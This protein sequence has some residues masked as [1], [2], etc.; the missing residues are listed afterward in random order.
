[1]GNF[2]RIA[3]TVDLD[4]LTHNFHIL[5]D[6]LPRGCGALAVVKADAYGHGAV[7]V[8]KVLEK[9][10][11]A[12]FAVATP[13]EGFA[14]R[15]NGIQTPIL[16]LGYS[17][18]RH[19]ARLAKEKITQSVFSSS[20]ADALASNLAD[21]PLTIHIKIDTGMT[22]LGFSPDETMSIADVCHRPCFRAEGIFTHF[23][24]ADEENTEYFQKQQTAFGDC[25]KG[26]KAFG[27]TFTHRHCANSAAAMR[28]FGEGMTLARF[29][30]SLYG[31]WPSVYMHSELVGKIHLESVMQLSARVA[32]IRDISAGTAIGYGRTYTAEK[33]MKIAIIT[34]GYADGVPRLW[35]NRGYVTIDG[36]SC[37]VVGRVCMDMM[38]VDVSSLPDP[39]VC[40][41]AVLFGYDGVD[42]DTA[43]SWAETIAYELFCGVSSRVP[44]VYLHGN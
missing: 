6:G 42:A 9:E 29:G 12:Y 32:Q 22:R 18:P 35:S 19:A 8:A 2:G 36:V 28:G 4:R 33:D 3:A 20:Y 17:D 40:D 16:I 41:Q 34:A 25:V 1:M 39:V 13:E 15:E 43:A 23:A 5:R 24:E 44:R 7:Q 37:P 30:I 38:M 10:G 26:L 21:E 14:L 11:A 31:A 27:V